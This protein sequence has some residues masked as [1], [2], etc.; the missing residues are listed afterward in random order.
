LFCF[1]TQVCCRS[2]ISLRS[3]HT[4]LLFPFIFNRGELFLNFTTCYQFRTSSLETYGRPIVLVI[5]LHDCSANRIYNFLYIF[6]PWNYVS[7]RYDISFAFRLQYITFHLVKNVIHAFLPLFNFISFTTMYQFHLYLINHTNMQFYL[8]CVWATHEFSSSNW[9][10]L[11]FS[12]SSTVVIFPIVIMFCAIYWSTYI[13]QLYI[14]FHIDCRGWHNS[15]DVEASGKT[16]SC[17]KVCN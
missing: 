9:F 13:L 8:E 4:S 1:V 11:L 6:L 16:H 14:F 17:C 15:M 3:V 12:T 5:D 7:L 2:I 10:A